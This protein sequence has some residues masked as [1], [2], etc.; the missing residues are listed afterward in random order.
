VGS[1]TEPWPKT[2]TMLVQFKRYRTLSISHVFK[3]IEN[4]NQLESAVTDFVWLR[5]GLKKLLLEVE[6]VKCAIAGD[7]DAFSCS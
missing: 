3:A 2:K 6:G 1:A 4:R 7:A 5:S